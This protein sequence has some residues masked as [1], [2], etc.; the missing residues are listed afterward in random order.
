MKQKERSLHKW[1]LGI[2]S[3]LLIASAVACT[4]VRIGMEDHGDL[5]QQ[6]AAQTALPSGNY[7]YKPAA[8]PSP[9]QSETDTSAPKKSTPAIGNDTH[10]GEKNPQ[11][12]T[13]SVKQE[14][15][16]VYHTPTDAELQQYDAQHE[17]EEQYPVLEFTSIQGSEAFEGIQVKNISS[18]ELDIEEEL[19]GKLGF[20]IEKNGEP[21]VLIYHTHTSESFLPFD[22]GYYYESFYPRSADRTQ[23]VC[24]IGEEI[25]KV[26]NQ[27]GIKAIHDMTVHD[28][29][30]YNEAYDRSYE[31]VMKNIQKYPSIKV[32]IDIHR[33]GLGS[34]YQRSKPVCMVDGKK[35]AQ[36]MILAGYNYADDPDFADWEYNLRFALQIQKNAVEMYPDL[37]RPL[38]FGDF[39]YNMDVNTGSLLIEVGADSNSIEEVRYTGYLLGNV[40]LRTLNGTTGGN[41]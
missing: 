12:D 1:G 37:A 2:S 4:V 13:S 16:F 34:E 6:M 21:Q 9:G 22:T 36:F 33:D 19:S 24:A 26:L 14:S 28:D 11:P 10:V 15:G 40:L 3:C 20:A 30:S 31:T 32:A 5:F 27:N 23:N 29:P 35:A 39:T 17:G 41:E 25:V 8:A 38:D 18:A 7:Q